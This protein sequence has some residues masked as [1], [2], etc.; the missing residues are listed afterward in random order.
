MSNKKKEARKKFIKKRL[1]IFIYSILLFPFVICMDL[2]YSFVL[3]KYREYM[4]KTDL[5]TP[6][7]VSGGARWGQMTGVAGHSPDK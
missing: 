2:M 5:P 6:L 7:V 3:K 1:R 4:E